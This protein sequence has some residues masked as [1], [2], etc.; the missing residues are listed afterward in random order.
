MVPNPIYDGDG[1]GPVYD[2]VHPQYETLVTVAPARFT[3]THQASSVTES[4]HY[5]NADVV[6]YVD[7]P[8]QL[9][10]FRSQSFA[11]NISDMD[12]GIRSSSRSYS[13]SLPTPR[14]TMLI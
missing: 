5:N 3:E 11:P 7:P 10:Q 6:R 14:Y 1:D 12:E 9:L 13:V 2:S 4:S 8:V